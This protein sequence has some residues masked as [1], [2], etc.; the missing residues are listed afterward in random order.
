LPT[1]H[2]SFTIILMSKHKVD[3]KHYDK[4]HPY[5]DTLSIKKRAN[6]YRT[7]KMALRIALVLFLV[8]AEGILM[9]ATADSSISYSPLQKE[10][11]AI[12]KPPIKI[13]KTEAK[14]SDPPPPLLSW[15]D[16]YLV[17]PRLYIN[18]PISGSA[19]V[20]DAGLVL[21][22]DFNRA[23]W[24][25]EGTKPG[26]TGSVVM[27][28]PYGDSSGDS[29]TSLNDKIVVGDTIEVIYKNGSHAVYKVYQI[30]SYKVAEVPL[31]D[32]FDKSDGKYLNLL[33]GT[34]VRSGSDGSYDQ[35]LVVYA[36]QD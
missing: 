33:T 4:D 10:V 24:R 27:S 17:I 32:I 8:L 36:K 9:W 7:Q 11:L 18:V 5:L 31:K 35:R 30:T 22:Q 29:V 15:S 21:P 13:I 16:M 34:G 26:E 2:K 28:G 19:L 3:Y 23:F 1:R 20:A 12:A 25:K 14:R 6:Y